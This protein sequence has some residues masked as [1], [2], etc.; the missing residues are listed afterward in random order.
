MKHSFLP[1]LEKAVSPLKEELFAL[2]S[3][4]HSHPEMGMEEFESSRAIMEFLKKYGCRIQNDFEGLPTA[5]IASS[6]EGRKENQPTFC[7]MGEYDALKGMGHGCGHNL[8][9][10]SG[11]AAFLIALVVQKKSGLPGNLLFFGTPGEEDA[12]GKV[13]MLEKG[14]FHNVD[15]GIMA[16]GYHRTSSDFGALAMARVKVAFYGKAS[17]AAF[18]PEKGINALDAMVAFYNGLLLWKKE[19]DP[20]ERVHG[21]ITHGGD[22]PNIIPEVTRGHFYIRSPRASRVDAMQKRLTAIA[23]KAAA[24]TG[25]R[26][27]LDWGVSYKNILY[28]DAINGTFR[29]IW[30]EFTGEILPVTDGTEGRGSTDAGDITYAFPSAQV[31]FGVTNGVEVPLHSHDFCKIAGSREAFE[32]ALKMGVA[33]AETALRYL[34]D[35]AFR[36]KALADFRKA[37]ELYS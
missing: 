2:S 7:F 34:S 32:M 19:I 36:E 4:I 9:A 28:N 20:S 29:E 1:E 11:V 31:H 23:E 21:I 6:G 5:F 14:M 3:F 17:H 27:E 30:K 35:P 13:K 16:H 37:Q 24:E 26:V 18:A 33:M 15:A 10:V 25:C 12:G 22:L 8:I